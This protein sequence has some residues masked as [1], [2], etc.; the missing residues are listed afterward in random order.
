MSRLIIAAFRRQRRRRIDS[1][2]FIRSHGVNLAPFFHKDAARIGGA[3][4]QNP[5]AA[6]TRAQKKLQTLI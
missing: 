6:G 3:A 1:S 4:L 2:L 5:L